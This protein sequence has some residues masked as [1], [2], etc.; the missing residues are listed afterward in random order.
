MKKIVLLI[1]IGLAIVSIVAFFV[2]N[3]QVAFGIGFVLLCGLLGIGNFYQFET[4]DYL[5]REYDHKRYV[6]RFKS[7]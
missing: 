2:G 4:R 7:K 6:E 3:Y 5:H 1:L